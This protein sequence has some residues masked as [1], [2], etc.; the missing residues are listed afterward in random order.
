MRA[1]SDSKKV[2]LEGV[3]L[4]VIT[5]EVEFEGE[6]NEVELSMV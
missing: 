2:S 3:I 6:L 4:F 1:G 5:N